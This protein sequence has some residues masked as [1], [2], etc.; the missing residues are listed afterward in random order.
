M[1]PDASQAE[2]TAIIPTTGWIG[3]KNAVQSVLRQSVPVIPLVVLDDPEVE[4]LVRRRLA[5]LDY[6]L[7]GTS[8][9]EGA[10]A[11]R[12]LGVEAAPTDYVAFLNDHD[13]WV[14]HKTEKQLAALRDSTRLWGK[15]VLSSRT[16]LVEES[17]RIVPEQLYDSGTRISNYVMDRST[18]R[19][20]RCLMSSSSLICHRDTAEWVP[21]DDTLNRYED[22][23]WLVRLQEAGIHIE[24]LPDV[25]VRVFPEP[26]AA[27]LGSASWHEADAWLESLPPTV[28]GRAR[29]DFITSIVARGAFESG[30]L[31]AGIKHLTRGLVSGAHPA[32]AVI[33]LAGLMHLGS[34]R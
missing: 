21:W 26:A 10:A 16:L 4:H 33:G 12:N 6:R 13:V 5:D 30:A 22:W 20:R 3:L 2:V 27:A 31:A 8:G 15:T 18:L 32:A 29:G 9:H 28:S 34:R 7:I 14:A 1:S 24:Q 19:V 11:A 25:L 23:D 17:S